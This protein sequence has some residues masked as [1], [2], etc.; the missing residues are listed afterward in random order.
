MRNVSIHKWIICLLL[1]IPVISG[2]NNS[3]DVQE[4]FTGK[5]WRMTFIA[6]DKEH[7]WYPFPGVSEGVINS[8][9]SGTRSF[10]ITFTGSTSDNVIAGNFIGTG[11]VTMDGNWSANGE[12]NAFS[13]S[14]S[15]SSV[16]D[17]KDTLGKYIIAAIK[18]ST[19]YLGDE[20]NLYLYYKNINE[21][22][23]I[24]FKPEI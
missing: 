1:F 6:K 13:T 16:K 2:C 17:S 5:T 12:T 23:F 15:K 8:Y 21:T 22:F 4:I 14:I 20:N 24:A 3:D 10:S 7:R 18:K 9:I 19:S 11:S